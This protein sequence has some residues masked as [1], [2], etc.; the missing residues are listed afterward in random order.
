M[1][2]CKIY[3]SIVS[4]ILQKAHNLTQPNW[5]TDEVFDKLWQLREMQFRFYVYNPEMTAIK[6]GEKQADSFY[7]KDE[8][9]KLSKVK[10]EQFRSLDKL[11]H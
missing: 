10:C 3:S 4:L 11:Y 1:T 5:M 7:V 6:A 8:H 2:N 9:Q